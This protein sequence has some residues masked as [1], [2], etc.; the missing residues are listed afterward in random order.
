M[1][2]IKKTI[3]IIT[4]LV[5]TLSIFTST[6]F[7]DTCEHEWVEVYEEDDSTATHYTNYAKNYNNPEYTTMSKTGVLRTRPTITTYLRYSSMFH[8]LGPVD[9]DYHNFLDV[10]TSM[11]G[12]STGI[13]SGSVAARL[14]KNLP[15]NMV[16]DTDVMINKGTIWYPFAHSET[17]TDNYKFFQK[18]SEKYCTKCGASKVG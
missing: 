1:K 5:M 3:T 18:T 2:N 15:M 12:S 9:F 7:A 11:G 6:A 10:S 16:S 14:L 4:M 17:T 13:F 8:I